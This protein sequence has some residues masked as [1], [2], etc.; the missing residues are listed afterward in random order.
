MRRRLL[1]LAAQRRRLPGPHRCAHTARS[2]PSDTP[3]LFE[4][5]EDNTRGA[6]VTFLP[7]PAPPRLADADA[8]AA[9][10]EACRTQAR[11]Y[12]ERV[13]VLSR[14]MGPIVFVQADASQEVISHNL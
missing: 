7:L 1:G 5:M 6:A 14:R 13:R 4:F 11:Q 12:I 3:S 8:D 9:A 10:R 2:L